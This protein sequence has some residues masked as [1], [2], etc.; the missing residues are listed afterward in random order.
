MLMAL[1]VRRRTDVST[2]P[3]SGV[4]KRS[5]AK[6]AGVAQTAADSLLQRGDEFLR[7]LRDRD[8]YQIFHEPVPDSVAGYHDV[9]KRPMDLRTCA[10]K[11]HARRYGSVTEL[12]E[13]VQLMWS[14]AIMYNPPET[15]YHKQAVKLRSYANKLLDDVRKAM[16]RDAAALSAAEKAAEQTQ[17]GLPAPA[18]HDQKSTDHA[19]L[20][21]PNQTTTTGVTEDQSHVR[22]APKAPPS[23]SRRP[24]RPKPPNRVQ[25]GH[26]ASLANGAPSPAKPTLPQDRVV[27]PS[28]QDKTESP[29]V[30]AGSATTSHPSAS[31]PA[32]DTVT[33]RRADAPPRRRPRK[34][35]EATSE[36]IFV[37][38]PRWSEDSAGLETPPQKRRKAIFERSFD[39][40]V[41]ASAPTARR[42]LATLL[43]PELVM[44]S[45]RD[46]ML[47]ASE[48]VS[49]A[50]NGA[51]CIAHDPN[52][53]G[54]ATEDGTQTA[55]VRVSDEPFV[56]AN[57]TLS[58]DEVKPKGKKENEVEEPDTD[59]SMMSPSTLNATSDPI[60]QETK[61][62][63][64]ELPKPNQT[65]TPA[66]VQT[67]ALSPVPIPVVSEGEKRQ[68]AQLLKAHNID[69][70]F[71][72]QI[73]ECPDGGT[74]QTDQP[75]PTDP[76]SATASRARRLLSFNHSVLMNIRRDRAES[77]IANPA[78]QEFLRKRDREYIGHLTHGIVNVLSSV[79]PDSVVDPLDVIGAAATITGPKGKS[80]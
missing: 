53:K 3:P 26:S 8:A 66:P 79:R 65:W 33:L 11:L 1:S 74:R 28:R 58:V 69:A 18:R 62:E 56:N 59:A 44:R 27:T 19:I 45:D 35:R 31:T 7:K 77:E 60:P 70:S 71:L 61:A 29:N 63:P 12:D 14:N 52:L 36:E 41:H 73:Q 32:P 22:R 37:G 9:V 13:D 68:V 39:A 21:D 57:G 48:N 75:V 76:G 80:T 4:P 42:L 67:D 10:E 50:T 16:A 40:F 64:E 17:S 20:T 43:D 72:D 49:A 30:T 2:M 34:L 78:R 25:P 38:R 51:P 6:T 24:P 5:S 15:I 54:T 47:R 23:K 55:D 46:A